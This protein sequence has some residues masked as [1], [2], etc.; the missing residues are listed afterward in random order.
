MNSSYIIL[1]VL[2]G[3]ELLLYLDVTLSKNAVTYFLDPNLV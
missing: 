3:V 1:L 2:M